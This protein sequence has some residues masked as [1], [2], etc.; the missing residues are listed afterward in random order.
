MKPSCEKLILESGTLFKEL[1]HD[2]GW[3]RDISR[4][5]FTSY[6]KIKNRI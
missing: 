4:G 2:K 1:A 6:G 5:K 3:K